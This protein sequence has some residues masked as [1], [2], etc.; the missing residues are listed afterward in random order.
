M[1]CANTSVQA[2]DPLGGG[3][4]SCTLLATFSSSPRGS[5]FY[6]DRGEHCFRS[7]VFNYVHHFHFT[8][9]KRQCDLHFINCINKASMGEPDA[10]AVKFL[11]KLSRPLSNIPT[12]DHPIN[13][14]A[15]RFEV[16]YLNSD[17]LSQMD[18]DWKTYDAKDKG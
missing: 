12:G 11:E 16:E 2:L 6:G 15:T 14:V 10:E 1:A 18:G 3:G 8:E 5:F 7:P 13:I 17:Y 4:S 9:V